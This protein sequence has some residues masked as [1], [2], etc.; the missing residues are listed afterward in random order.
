MCPSP[1]GCRKSKNI[2]E[3]KQLQPAAAVVKAGKKVYKSMCNLKRLAALFMG[4][5]TYTDTADGTWY[6]DSVLWASRSTM[7][8]WVNSLG[9]PISAD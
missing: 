8:E 6:G 1:A 9:L 7:V 3:H 5:D 2:L 4:R